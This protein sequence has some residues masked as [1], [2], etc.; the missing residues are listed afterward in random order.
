MTLRHHCQRDGCYKDRLPDWGILDGCFPRGIRPSDID[1]C[2][3]INGHFLMLEWKPRNGFLT[4][5]QLLMFQGITAGTTRGQVVVIY[6]DPGVPAE[7][8]VW[9]R[10]N[11]QFRQACDLAF[12]RWFCEQWGVV[13]GQRKAA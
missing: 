10:G 11:R 3:E 8:E 13:A 2:V 7:I 6:G 5:G 1:G 12:L 9:Q 4:R